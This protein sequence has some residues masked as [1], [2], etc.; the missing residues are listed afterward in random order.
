MPEEVKE[1]VGTEVGNGAAVSETPVVE[2]KSEAVV[3]VTKDAEP[4]KAEAPPVYQPNFK[5]KVM[6]EEKEVDEFLRS[7]IKDA[8]TEKKVRELYEKAYGLDHV[9]PKYEET[10]KKYQETEGKYQELYSWVEDTVSMREKDFW[11][12][13]ERVGLTKEQVAKHVLE[14]VKR[15]E[16]PEDQKRIYDELDKTRREKLFL[17][18]QY[19]EEQSRS[20]QR[21]V[22]ART[23]ELDTTLQRPEIAAYAKAYDAARKQPGAF[24]ERV[25]R[26]GI[27]EWHVSKRDVTPEQAV[28]ETMSFLGDSYKSVA[29]QPPQ[30]PSAEDKPLPVIPKVSGKSVSPTGKAPRS[31]E[32][33]KKLAAEAT[34]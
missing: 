14:E 25:I 19:Q 9:K 34:R 33:L 30:V 31:I 22:Q 4:P 27:A 20:E 17:E 10:K 28:M 11:G 23:H 13:M 21:A 16:L 6:D 12:F 8:E 1:V 15:L 2:T 24:R 32:D 7:A 5:F 26:H 3:E 29:S 18:K